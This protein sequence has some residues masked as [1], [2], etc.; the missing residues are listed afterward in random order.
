MS[1]APT[2]PE[3]LAMNRIGSIHRDIAAM[4]RIGQLLFDELRGPFEEDVELFQRL[5][6]SGLPVP[7]LSV[8]H[9]NRL[10]VPWTQYLAYMLD[11]RKSGEIG[12]IVGPAV[13]SA[14]AK[15]ATPADEPVSTVGPI[16]HE[17]LIVK[18]EV[19]LGSYCVHCSRKA[20]IDLLLI[21]PSTVVAIEQKVSSSTWTYD[22]C[23]GGLEHKQLSEYAKLLPNWIE[24]HC[25]TSNLSRCFL[26]I[27]QRDLTKSERDEKWHCVTHEELSDLVAD[28][29]SRIEGQLPAYALSSMLLD[30]NAQPF[31]SWPERIND[32]KVFLERVKR[33]G[34]PRDSDLV[35]YHSFRESEERLY[36]FLK[37]LAD[38]L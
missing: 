4:R 22:D 6:A 3:I 7:V 35:W 33:G 25:P 13:F 5:F 15:Y 2:A 38:R 20:I 18:A 27:S 30:W 29:L 36:G 24:E 37:N 23:P 28:C 21:G 16:N 26:T 17:D 32:L 1:S 12:R 31:G 10:E 19:E 34:A 8:S 9:A 14:L 11:P